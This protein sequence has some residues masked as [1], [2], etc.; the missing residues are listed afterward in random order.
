MIILASDSV[1][2][3]RAFNKQGIE[4]PEQN[5]KSSQRELA[6]LAPEAKI[7]ESEGGKPS[8]QMFYPAMVPM[9]HSKD[10]HGNCKVVVM[11]LLPWW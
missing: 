4:V 7:Q 2:K 5:W 3:Y 11:V 1:A 9:D 6:Y 10:Q 8:N